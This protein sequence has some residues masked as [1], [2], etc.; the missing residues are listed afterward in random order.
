MPFQL[1]QSLRGITSGTT[2]KLRTA[3]QEANLAD[4]S[5][6]KLGFQLFVNLLHLSA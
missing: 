5:F 4:H 2:Q 6:G 3:Q 1:R